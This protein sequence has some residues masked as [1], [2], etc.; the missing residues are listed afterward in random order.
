MPDDGSSGTPLPASGTACDGR[1]CNAANGHLTNASSW[2]RTDSQFRVHNNT[3]PC[4]GPATL[5]PQKPWPTCG[6]VFAPRRPG[7][8]PRAGASNH[9]RVVRVIEPDNP[10]RRRRL[11]ARSARLRR[12]LCD[13]L[14]QR[15]CLDC[16]PLHGVTNTYCGWLLIDA[17]WWTVNPTSAQG[18]HRLRRGRQRARHGCGTGRQLPS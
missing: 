18:F 13:Y 2:P 1:R 4:T 17:N 3:G 9:F 11:K 14:L 16:D 10:R 7:R 6:Q 15:T 5:R 12:V 8:T